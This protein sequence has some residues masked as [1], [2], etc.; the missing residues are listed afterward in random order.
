MSQW[1]KF[2]N[3]YLFIKKKKYREIHQLVKLKQLAWKKKSVYHQKKKKNCKILQSVVQKTSKFAS[4]SW[5]KSAIFFKKLQKVPQ[6][7]QIYRW[8][9]SRDLLI[10]AGKNCKILQSIIKNKIMQNESIF[11]GKK[12]CYLCKLIGKK[13]SQNSPFIKKKLL[14][15]SHS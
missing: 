6:I 2:K 4:S 7:L 15:F 13:K 8:K 11:F 3:C 12:L 1:K 10:F 5:E 9:K 14:Q